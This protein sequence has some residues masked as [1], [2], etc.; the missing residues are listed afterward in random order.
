ME[1][2]Q[3]C[4]DISLLPGTTWAE[5]RRSPL[6]A[7]WA[8]PG[9]LLSGRQALL[10]QLLLQR[11]LRNLLL[12]GKSETVLGPLDQTNL[13]LMLRENLGLGP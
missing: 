4:G 12:C 3:A 11:H 6:P 1:R 7:S 2:K 9:R 13:P 5:C 10:H 8:Q